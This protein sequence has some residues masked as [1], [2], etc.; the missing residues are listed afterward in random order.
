MEVKAVENKLK[1]LK[2]KY[3]ARPMKMVTGVADAIMNYI[4]Y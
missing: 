3:T 2:G 1:Y 4:N